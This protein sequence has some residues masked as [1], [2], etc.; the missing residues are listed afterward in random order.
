MK[1]K[2]EEERENKIRAELEE[3]TKKIN[4]C[5]AIIE[6]KDYQTEEFVE[7]AKVKLLE[8][9]RERQRLINL[10]NIIS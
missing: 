10:L 9:E 6:Y 3:I 5:N 4:D 7:D 2:A 1:T 8:Y